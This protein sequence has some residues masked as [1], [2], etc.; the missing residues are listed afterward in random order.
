MFLSLTLP[1]ANISDFIRNEYPEFSTEIS[2]STPLTSDFEEPVVVT[3]ACDPEKLYSE[4]CSLNL[5]PNISD[6]VSDHEMKTNDLSQVEE[7]ALSNKFVKF[8]Q[9][10]NHFFINKFYLTRMAQA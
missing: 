4:P 2:S 3:D 5:T 6:T 7:R 1:L 10:S 8:Y 9:D